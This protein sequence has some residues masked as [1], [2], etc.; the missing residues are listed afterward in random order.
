MPGLR[1]K[2]DSGV[3]RASLLP[4][5]SGIIAESSDNKRGL[6]RV[7]KSLESGESLLS[8]A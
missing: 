2:V 6:S 5:K 7:G 1:I 4:N 8:R 3:F